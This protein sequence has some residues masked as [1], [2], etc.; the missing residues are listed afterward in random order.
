MT[1]IQS[2]ETD[3]SR[4]HPVPCLAELSALSTS[5]RRAEATTLSGLIRSAAIGESGCSRP[6]N[7]AAGDATCRPAGEA[8]TSRPLRRWRMAAGI[9]RGTQ[10]L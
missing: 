5:L 8:D 2:D 4:I 3:G 10:Q 9:A 1:G 6:A 7:H